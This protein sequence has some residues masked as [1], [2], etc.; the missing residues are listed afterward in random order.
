MSEV[1]TPAALTAGG[2]AGDDYRPVTWAARP[3]EALQHD[4]GRVSGW[5]QPSTRSGRWPAWSPL[6]DPP[7][8][9]S[10]GASMPT[11]PACTTSLDN[12]SHDR[13]RS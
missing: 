6:L 9:N 10:T 7:R 3:I 13:R 12:P 8:G 4:G 5:L 1:R 11:S 2:T